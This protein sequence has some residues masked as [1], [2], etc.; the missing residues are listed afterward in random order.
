VHRFIS[1]VAGYLRQALTQ[2]DSSP[3]GKLG[4]ASSWM[5]PI[6]VEWNVLK[7][8]RLHRKRRPVGQN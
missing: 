5:H 8:F 4:I 7:P 2:P 6:G 3:A 1:D